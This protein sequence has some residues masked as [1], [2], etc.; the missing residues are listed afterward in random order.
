MEFFLLSLPLPSFFASPCGH[1][2]S[3]LPIQVMTKA[4]GARTPTQTWSS[5][6]SSGRRPAGWGSR[7]GVMVKQR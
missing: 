1:D 3:P 5:R 2:P 6:G 4:Q 7:A